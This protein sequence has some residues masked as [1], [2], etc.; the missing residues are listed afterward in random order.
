MDIEQWQFGWQKTYEL[1]WTSHLDSPTNTNHWAHAIGPGITHTLTWQPN[2]LKFEVNGGISGYASWQGTDA[3]PSYPALD[4]M[5]TM[6]AWIGV[7]DHTDVPS[8]N[9]ASLR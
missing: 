8:S 6:Y 9:P 2:L 5:S 3:T 4:T 7:D 1:D